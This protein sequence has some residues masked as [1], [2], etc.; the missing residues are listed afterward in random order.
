MSHFSNALSFQFKMKYCSKNIFF[1][2]SR[3][4]NVKTKYDLLKQETQNCF[5]RLHIMPKTTILENN[6]HAKQPT[7]PFILQDLVQSCFAF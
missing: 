7:N 6:V 5:I 4:R 3:P 2:N 1:V